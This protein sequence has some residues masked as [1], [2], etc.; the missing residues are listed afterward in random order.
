MPGKGRAFNYTQGDVKTPD[1]WLTPKNA[2]F[3]RES[4]LQ[5]AV[6]FGG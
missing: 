5:C 3:T 6:E 4:W 1:N 2:A